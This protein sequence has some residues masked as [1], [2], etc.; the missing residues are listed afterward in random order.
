MRNE[1]LSFSPLE[2]GIRG[3]F[4]L[5]AS[6]LLLV[7]AIAAGIGI[8]AWQKH[9]RRLH[10]GEV[11]SAYARVTNSS[12]RLALIERH[13]NMPQS[14]LWLLQTASAQFQE[15]A[16]GAA[17]KSFRLFVE[18]YPKHPLR[19]AA[20][21]GTAVGSE[22]EGKR[23]EAARSYRTVIDEQSTDPYRLIA[24][25]NL[26]RLDIEQ[27]QY[28]PAKALLDSIRRRRPVNRFEGEVQDLQDRLPP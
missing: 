25:I 28:A 4:P 5:V 26:A 24:E 7:A 10:W 14:A 6:L 27:K 3:G 23:E 12:E 22:A 13:R 11:A 2:D 21:L 19:P 18:Y 15:G 20:L 16:Y 1:R 17:T 9:A 8:Y